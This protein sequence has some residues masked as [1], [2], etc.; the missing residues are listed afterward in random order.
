MTIADVQALGYET[1]PAFTIGNKAFYVISGFGLRLYVGDTD[2][3]TLDSI[4]D[5]AGDTERKFQFNR[6]DAATARETL[7]AHGCTVARLAP[8][9]NAFAV[10]GTVNASNV[11]ADGLVT[12]AATVE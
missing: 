6:P 10:A 5:P 1:A 2:T 9:T 11:D 3:D 7:E 4:T 12:L 8:T